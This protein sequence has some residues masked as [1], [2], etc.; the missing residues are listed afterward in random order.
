MAVFACFK[1]M[2]AKLARCTIHSSCGL[3]QRPVA[4]ASHGLCTSR[5]AL[6]SWRQSRRVRN[7]RGVCAPNM[8]QGNPTPDTR[9]VLTKS[10]AIAVYD[11][12]ALHACHAHLS[13]CALHN[14]FRCKHTAWCFRAGAAIKDSSSIYGGVA[15]AIAPAASHLHQ[16]LLLII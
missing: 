12:Y 8:S 13:C 14:V 3:G 7:K 5:Y 15:T 9:T 16:F 10:Q 4:V 11:R 2:H 1:H 6:L